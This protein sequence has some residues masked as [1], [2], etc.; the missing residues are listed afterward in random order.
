MSDGTRLRV[1]GSAPPNMMFLGGA[2]QKIVQDLEWP[3]TVVAQHRLRVGPA[4]C[5]AE[6]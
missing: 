5:V 6:M 3:R 2:I 1:L 4:T